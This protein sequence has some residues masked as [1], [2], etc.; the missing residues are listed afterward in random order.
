[1]KYTLI[2]FFTFCILFFSCEKEDEI[3]NSSETVKDSNSN[4]PIA[5]DPY[6]YICSARAKK[7]WTQRTQINIGQARETVCQ[8]FVTVYIY[9]L[10]GIE[11]GSLDKSST[12]KKYDLECDFKNKYL[13][14][15]VGTYDY[16]FKGTSDTR[17]YIDRRYNY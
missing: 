14:V 2:F 10:Y 9:K 13:G 3:P 15:S 1:M 4:K 11:Y 17:Y 16:H 5:N 12:S 6:T 8:D 7:I